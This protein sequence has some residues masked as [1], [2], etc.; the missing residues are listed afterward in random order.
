MIKRTMKMIDV[1]RIKKADK[2]WI[3]IP[4]ETYG[5]KESDIIG[6]ND[7]IIAFTEKFDNFTRERFISTDKIISVSYEYRSD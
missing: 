6:I 5:I 2:I 3:R 1:D 7:N 4:N